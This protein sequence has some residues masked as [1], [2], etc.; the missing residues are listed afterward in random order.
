MATSPTAILN[1]NRND[2][3]VDRAA[4]WSRSPIWWA[5]FADTLDPDGREYIGRMRAAQIT[6]FLS[7]TATA[8]W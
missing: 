3:T 8:E 4:I 5:V 6:S 2:P 7:W 1:N